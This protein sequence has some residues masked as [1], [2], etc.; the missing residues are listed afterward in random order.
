MAKMDT[1]PNRVTSETMQQIKQGTAKDSVMASLCHLVGSG[2]PA[3][4]KGTPEYLR[5]YWSF[6]NEMRAERSP[7]GKKCFW[8]QGLETSTNLGYMVKLLEPGEK[9][10]DHTVSLPES[11]LTETDKPVE[12]EPAPQ[13]DQ[14]PISML[15][16]SMRQRRPPSRFRDCCYGL[17]R[18][19]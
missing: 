3:E 6:R 1:E 17:K 11:E 13:G 19:T 10:E 14:E 12:Q 2:R 7:R 5:Q 4:M 15:C 18:T 9:L 16:C 8:N